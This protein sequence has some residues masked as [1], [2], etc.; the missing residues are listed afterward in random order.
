MSFDPSFWLISLDLGKVSQ[1]VCFLLGSEV[2]QQR[3]FKEPCLDGTLPAW[4][5]LNPLGTTAYSASLCSEF[6]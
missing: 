3:G 2:S 4:P 6:P 5:G 1:E